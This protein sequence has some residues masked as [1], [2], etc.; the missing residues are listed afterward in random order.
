MFWQSATQN[1]LFCPSGAG[2]S[3]GN[4]AAGPSAN[5]KSTDGSGHCSVEVIACSNLT[6]SE[7]MLNRY[8]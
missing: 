5:W 8:S 2:H 7:L 1:I 4:P 3:C 6:N